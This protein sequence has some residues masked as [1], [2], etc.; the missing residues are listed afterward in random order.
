MNELL[1]LYLELL[2]WDISVFSSPWLYIPLLIPVMFFLPFF[3]LKWTVLTAPLWIPC[4]MI[5]SAARKAVRK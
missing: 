4:G 5:W 1:H 3:F 2:K